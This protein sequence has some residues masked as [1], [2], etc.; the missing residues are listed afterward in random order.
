MQDKQRDCLPIFVS[1]VRKGHIASTSP[2]MIQNGSFMPFPPCGPSSPGRVQV[3]VLAVVSGLDCSLSLKASLRCCKSPQTVD[4]HSSVLCGTYFCTMCT[5]CVCIVD[6]AVPLG[7]TCMSECSKTYFELYIMGHV[8]LCRCDRSITGSRS[9][10]D[11][12]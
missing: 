9:S 8:T 11:S 3:D 6:S 5:L 12:F 7:E 4:R 1:T 2:Q 10:L